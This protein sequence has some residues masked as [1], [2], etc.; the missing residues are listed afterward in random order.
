MAFATSRI[1]IAT[2]RMAARKM[3]AASGI[4]NQ[5]NK[6]ATIIPMLISMKEGFRQGRVHPGPTE[7]MSQGQAA[8]GC[9][10]MVPGSGAP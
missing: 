8:P 2:A 6:N 10:A 5:A 1:G 7:A 4:K 3:P 9:S